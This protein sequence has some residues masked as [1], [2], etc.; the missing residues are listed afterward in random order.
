[1]QLHSKQMTGC[2]VFFYSGY[3]MW[4]G[5]GPVLQSGKDAIVAL[6]DPVLLDG[7]RLDFGCSNSHAKTDLQDPTTC[8]HGN[9]TKQASLILLN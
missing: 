9:T 6:N 4:L 1:M 8:S 7:E 3:L 2:K 5:L